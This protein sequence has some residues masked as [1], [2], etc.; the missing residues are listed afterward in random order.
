MMVELIY[1][2]DCP[3]VADARSQLIKAFG[4]MGIAARWREWER[5]AL[6][7]PDYARAFG[8]PTILVDGKDIAG[9]VPDADTRACRVYGD[10]HGKLGGTPSVATICA[11]LRDSS[12]LTTT[13][14]KA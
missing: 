6:D 8:S 10:E 13:G 5:A 4:Q 3:N 9:V 14:D 11:A 12:L 1:D 2:A 7:T